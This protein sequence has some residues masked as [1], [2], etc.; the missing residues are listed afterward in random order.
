M[1]YRRLHRL[2]LE[3]NARLYHVKSL[4]MQISGANETIKAT[5]ASVSL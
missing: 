5:R 3:R 1:V 2:R 4:G